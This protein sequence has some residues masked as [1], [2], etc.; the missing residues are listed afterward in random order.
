VDIQSPLCSS[1]QRLLRHL[2]NFPIHLR[3]AAQS[4]GQEGATL[5]P[6]A[7]PDTNYEDAA[8]ELNK[9]SDVD[10]TVIN[11]INQTIEM[12]LDTC[13]AEELSVKTLADMFDFRLGEMPSK[14]PL[15]PQTT[16]GTKGPRLQDVNVER[17]AR[18]LS[19]LEP[20]QSHGTSLQSEC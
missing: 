2:G 12:R 3:Q 16:G 1:D 5:P 11:P 17:I 7:T 9:F 10:L 13:G 20:L 19:G 14:P 8:V 4:W 6:T 18:Q 15:T